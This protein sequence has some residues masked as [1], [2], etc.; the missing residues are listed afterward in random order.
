WLDGMEVTQFTYFQQVGGIDLKP[1]SL[2]L[3][4]GLERIAM[5]LQG[6]DN[7]YNLRWNEDFLYGDIHRQDEV[8]CSKFNFELADVAMLRRHFDDF[9]GQSHALVKARLTLPAYEYCL[10][11][12][13]VFN[14]LDARGAI[15][16][17]ER[18]GY[19]ARVRA[20]ARLCAETYL[21]NN[22]ADLP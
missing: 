3:T 5:Y 10:K 9:H 11:C 16:V 4:Y 19:I 7:V 17:N 1:I 2:E 20:L 6:V 8:E 13:H 18:T 21:L 12:S 22:G 15:S 14:L